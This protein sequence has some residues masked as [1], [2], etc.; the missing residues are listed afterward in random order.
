MYIDPHVYLR[1]EKYT[2]LRTIYT[3]HRYYYPTNQRR[4][5]HTGRLLVRNT[6]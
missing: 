5:A 2:P 1:Q 4:T 3:L 6:R